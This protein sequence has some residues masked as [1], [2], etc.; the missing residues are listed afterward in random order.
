VV[1][2][3]A[4]GSLLGVFHHLK[5]LA[6][7]INFP[8]KFWQNIRK[9]NMSPTAVGDATGNEVVTEMWKNILQH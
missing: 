3:Q 7:A 8:K 5:C 1:I 2:F 6:L 4:G 9:K